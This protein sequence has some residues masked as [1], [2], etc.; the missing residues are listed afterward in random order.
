MLKSVD[1]DSIRVV[2]SYHNNRRDEFDFGTII[3]ECRN[4][5]PSLFTNSKVD[6]IRRYIDEAVN[7]LVKTVIFYAG[8]HLFI[9][10][11]DCNQNIIMN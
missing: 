8:F 11:L 6:F 2:D 10:I 5:F 1:F 7:S 9:E 4:T 3:R